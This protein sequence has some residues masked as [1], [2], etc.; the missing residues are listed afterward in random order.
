VIRD[1][2]P[3]DATDLARVHVSS[4]QT[5]YR[6]LID[7]AFLDAMTVQ[8]RIERWDALLSHL[9]GR[10]LVIEA[11][12]SVV[13]FCSIGPTELGEW[14]EVYAI[15]LAPAR[16]GEGLGRDLLVAGETALAEVGHT[17]ALLW[18]LEANTRA[19]AFYE[20]QGWVLGKPI[21]IENIGGRDVTEVR[22]ERSL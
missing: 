20:R 1:A 12:Q 4:W 2:E 17:R 6:G 11:N 9:R 22:Y 8:S 21:R 15:Y 3:R 16:W 7:Q 14:G 13:G 5:A 10:V 19:R 18:V